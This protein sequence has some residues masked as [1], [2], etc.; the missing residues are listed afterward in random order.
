MKPNDDDAAFAVALGA[1]IKAARTTRGLDQEELAARIN[2]G[3]RTLSRYETGERD[4]SL[5][6]VRAIAK[7]LNIDAVTILG[8]AE[9][10]S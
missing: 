3:V 2:L 8:M 7:A 5:K 4:A 10:L 6:T 1:A 9:E